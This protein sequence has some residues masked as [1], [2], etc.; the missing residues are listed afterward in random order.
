MM[1]C[2]VEWYLFTNV[3]DKGSASIFGIK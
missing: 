1:T 3:S 2:R